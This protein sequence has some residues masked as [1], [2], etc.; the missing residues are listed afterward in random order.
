MAQIISIVNQKGGVGKT[1][2]AI[3]LACYLATLGKFVL[4]VDMDPQ[5][6]ATS[7]LGIDYNKLDKGIYE[8]L[9]GLHNIKDVI[10]NTAVAGYKIAPSTLNLAGANVELVNLEN[11]ELKLDQAL[12][13]VRNDYDYI[14]I[15]CP[16][17][18]GLLTLNCLVAAEKLL[19][20]VQAEYYALEG[21]GQLIKTINL[22]K[23]HIK[24]DLDILG[25][26]LTM[27]DKRT[28]LSEEILHQLYQYFPNRIFRSV[29]PRNVRLTEAPSF[30]K[31]ILEYDP[32]SKG[33]KAYERLA[34]EIIDLT[35]TN[36]N[37]Y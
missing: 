27:Y 34:R 14:I 1:T 5:A 11:R 22:I 29:I 9:L 18:L 28:K 32:K 37:Y 23:T 26:V 7:G 19:I 2:T 10:L 6:N 13:S 20:P 30:G 4:L 16:P 15:D 21:L 12:L 36:I 17:S 8:A 3:N 25:A 31:T 33:A 35:N 24:A